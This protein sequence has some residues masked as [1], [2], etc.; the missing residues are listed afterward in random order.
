M[1]Y[2][3]QVAVSLVLSTFEITTILILTF[4]LFRFKLKRYVISMLLIGAVLSYCSYEIREGFRLP[5]IVDTSFQVV[6][7]YLIFRFIYRIGYFYSFAMMAKGVALYMVINYAISKITFFSIQDSTS[8]LH[9]SSY[10]LQ[11]STILCGLIA[12]YLMRRFNIGVSYV[13]FSYKERVIY[14][15]ANKLILITGFFATLV[16]CS[17]LISIYLHWDKI[18][19]MSMI[20]M[21]I[22]FIILMRLSYVKEYDDQDG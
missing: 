22:L 7:L 2:W 17:T 18:L 16:F 15:G 5:L 11:L 4:V 8:A 12:A 10:I 14:K 20:I 3:M 9:M 19:L 1:S 13:P 21:F 6:A